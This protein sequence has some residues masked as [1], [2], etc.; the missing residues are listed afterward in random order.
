MLC[1]SN[2]TLISY[3]DDI[4]IAIKVHKLE[5]KLQSHVAC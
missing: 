2:S 5:E 3:I 1:D 4:A